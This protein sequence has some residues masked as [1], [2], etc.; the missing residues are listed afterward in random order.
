MHISVFGVTDAV[1]KPKM[2]H[3]ANVMA[4]HLDNDENGISDNLLAL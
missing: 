4:Q 1:P 3:D 2:E